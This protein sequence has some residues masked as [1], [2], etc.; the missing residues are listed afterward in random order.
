M[1]FYIDHLGVCDSVS[2]SFFAIDLYRKL[3]QTKG[4]SRG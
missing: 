4:L 3:H 1:S 2:M